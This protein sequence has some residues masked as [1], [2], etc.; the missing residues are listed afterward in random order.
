LKLGTENKTK[1]IVAVALVALALW[2]AVH[3]F[4]SS[5]PTARA[6][7]PAG[8]SGTPQAA[9]RVKNVVPRSQQKKNAQVATPS[10]DPRLR[11]DL[12]RSSEQIAYVGTGRNIFQDQPERIPRPAPRPVPQPQP[13]PGPVP[14]PPPPPIN[15]RFFGF[16]NRPGEAKQIFLAE[17]D[18]VFIAKQGD[19]VDRRYKV[20][21]IQQNSVV[22]EDVL[23]NNRQTIP[24]VQG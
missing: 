20:I 10:L 1:T 13:Q 9:R 5:P 16:A 14:P 2:S 22:I 12:L 21:Q 8:S 23:N 6:S 4:S 24:L 19:I 3:Y 15:L 18:D 17:G 11:L 7:S